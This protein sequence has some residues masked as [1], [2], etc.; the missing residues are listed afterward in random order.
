MLGML[1]ISVCFSTV[2]LGRNLCLQEKE[3]MEFESLREKVIEE[4]EK[5][6]RQQMETEP[7]WENLKGSMNEE[8]TILP[9]YQELAKWNPDFAG[10]IYIK[11]TYIDYPVMQS[12]WEP[13]Y[14]LHRNFEGEDSYAGV[15]FVGSGDMKNGEGD[16]SL[17][18]H[19]MRNGTMF[20]ELL[21]YQNWDYY[22]THPFVQ[23]DTLREHRVYEVVTVFYANEDDWKE[24]ESLIFSF[25][26]GEKLDFIEKVKG[27]GLYDTGVMPKWDASLLLLITCSYHE[28]NERFIVVS[29]LL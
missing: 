4:R 22:E 19:N 15:P 21:R 2:I 24:R 1:V 3:Q 11:G 20:A 25:F 8:Q 9:E 18:G 10:W 7:K 13:E 6:Q 26:N 14:Y 29:Q 16:I 27:A 17:Y 28:K 5:Y 12:F 23:L